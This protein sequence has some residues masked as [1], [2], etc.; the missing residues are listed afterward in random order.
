MTTISSTGSVTFS[1]LASGI[2]TDS[3]IESILEVESAPKTLL[4]NKIEYLET[5]KET[6]EEFNTLLDTF[7][8]SVLGVNNKSDI[9]SFEV[10]NSGSDYFSLSTTSLANEGSYSVE[11]VSL[12]QQ[13][14]DIGAEYV[15]DLDTTTLSGTLQIGEETVSYDGTTLEDL[16]TQINDGDYG[17]TASVVNDGS[18]NG[19][20]LMLT[21]DTAGDEIDIVGTGDITLDTTADGHTVDGSKAEVVV[22]GV[23]YYNTSNTITSAIKGATL[24]LVDTSDGATSK[25]SIASD[26]EDVIS[27]KLQEIV[28]AYNAINEYVDTIYDSDPTLGNTMKTVQRSLKNYLTSN[29]LI[30]LGIETDWETGELSFDTD[31]FTAAYEEDSDGMITAL[32]GDDDSDGIMTQL[33]AY[34]TDQMNA[35]SGFFALKEDKI[36]E[37]VTRLEDNITAMESRL[38]KRQTTLAAQFQVMEELISTLNSTGD[39][40]TSFFDS[41]NTSSS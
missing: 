8:A 15:A 23:T 20:R 11:V 36:D 21:A 33:D 17:V 26:A 40:L 28:D 5:Q 3:I 6:Y 30:N 12:A 7:Y 4:E 27:T 29:D 34:I 41:Y 2:D 24:T 14:K 32:F 39:Y 31:V 35:T 13:Q 38:E 19:Y 22:D 37:E 1:G 10:T 18:G 25:V 16:V 9:K